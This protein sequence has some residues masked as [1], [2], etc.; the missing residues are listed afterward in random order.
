MRD[1]LPVALI[2]WALTLAAGAYLNM[3][4]RDAYAA[5]GAPLYRATLVAPSKVLA[6][7]GGVS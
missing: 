3:A 5:P 4:Y 6:G 2:V 1:F 7:P